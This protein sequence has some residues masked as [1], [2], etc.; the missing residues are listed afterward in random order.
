LGSADS[1][2]LNKLIRSPHARS[3][4]IGNIR[5]L[6]ESPSVIRGFD[7]RKI[8]RALSKAEDFQSISPGMIDVLTAVTNAIR[9][10][11]VEG[12]QE[13]IDLNRILMGQ[14]ESQYDNCTGGFITRIAHTFD[15]VEPISSVLG[16]SL[17]VPI[18]EMMQSTAS[19]FQQEGRT[20]RE[21]MEWAVR[22]FGESGNMYGQS[23]RTMAGEF[24]AYIDD[25]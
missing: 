5:R 20:G 15:G 6:M 11:T 2:G 23:T 12:S 9:V 13:S 19:R 1:D 7:V 14:L 24:A 8:N 3:S 21:F 4:A 17:A 16:L 22:E 25:A 18:G 10:S